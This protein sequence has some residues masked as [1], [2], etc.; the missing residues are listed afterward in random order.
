MLKQIE[1][2][3]GSASDSKKQTLNIVPENDIIIRTLTSIEDVTPVISINDNLKA[4]I[5]SGEI[6]GKIEYEV[7]G[8]KY[9]TNLIA[10]NN[11]LNS[12]SIQYIFD[13]LLILL[14]VIIL[15]TIFNH[16]RKKHN[17]NSNYSFDFKR[18]Y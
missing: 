6:V 1:I 2:D 5:L 3:T 16:R 11:V 9:S 12:L 7:D 17:Q 15:F 10:D 8:I 14:I 18:F 13:F 4:P